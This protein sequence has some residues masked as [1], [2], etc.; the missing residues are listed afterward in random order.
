MKSVLFF[1][2]LMLLTAALF[3][4]NFYLVAAGDTSDPVLGRSASRDLSSV[5]AFFRRAADHA[6]LGF[7]PSILRDK[8]QNW[9]R[10]DRS[11]QGITPDPSDVLVV[12]FSTD[13]RKSA[14][15]AW[16]DLVMEGQMRNLFALTGEL[17]KKNAGLLLVMADTSQREAP[18]S[19]TRSSLI[20]GVPSAVNRGWYDLFLRSRGTVILAAAE[21]GESALA[22]PEGGALT[23]TVL[24]TLN[25]NLAKAVPLTWGEILKEVSGLVKED[26]GGLQNPMTA[27]EVRMPP[28]PQPGPLPILP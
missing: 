18:Q 24:E 28:A 20:P 23:V 2:G 21:S 5:E 8:D 22:F 4:G 7:R 10:W 12:Y 11:L 15:N 1:S 3:S 6:G 25:R 27:Q 26:T 17:K 9:G 16:P 13:G 19:R 14:Q